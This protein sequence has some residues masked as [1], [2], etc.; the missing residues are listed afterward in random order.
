M[1]IQSF[2]Y[3][4]WKLYL[5][6]LVYNE[7]VVFIFSSAKTLQISYI[8]METQEVTIKPRLKVVLKSDA[9]QIDEVIVESELPIF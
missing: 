7:H 5:Q 2:I 1:Y 8:G 4:P 6:Q 9:K 3:V